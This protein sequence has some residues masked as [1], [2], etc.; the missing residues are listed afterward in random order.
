MS[1][2]VVIRPG[3]L[4]VISATW[5]TD[6]GTMERLAPK[7][8]GMPIPVTFLRNRG[9]RIVISKPPFPRTM[10]VG[11]GAEMIA[12]T[13]EKRA[14]HG[15]GLKSDSTVATFQS[16]LRSDKKKKAQN[17]APNAH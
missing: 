12:L 13:E 8:G 7:L 10:L 15:G 9:V 4:Q 17:A 1:E 6:L 5:S 16:W 14:P 2:Y 11:E 3:T